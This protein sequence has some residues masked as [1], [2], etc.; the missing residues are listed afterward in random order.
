MEYAAGAVDLHC[1]LLPGIDDGAPDWETTLSMARV[2][3]ADGIRT[4]VATPHWPLD[5]ETSG[6]LV[7]ELAA[8][9]QARLRAEEVPL[10]VLPGHEL[11]I[12]WELEESLASGEALPLGDSR[13]VLLETP[14]FELPSYLRDLIFRLQGQSYRP[15]LAHP[16]RNPTVQKDPARLQPLVEAGCLLQ[17]NGGSLLGEFGSLP[18]RT[19]RALMRRG[20]VQIL[21]S[22]AHSDA[23]RPPR[24][25]RAA[26]AAARSVGHAA[27]QAMIGAAPFAVIQDNLPPALP[28]EPARPGLVER[29]LGRA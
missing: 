11:Q 5:G 16:E 2:A 9:A 21:A 23:D 26:R 8:E 7:R 20:W 3:A 29:L 25:A 4:I 18:R 17:V 27:A 22:D 24:L 10:R 12:V 14:Y 15:I 13:F 6:P 28:L 1:H 19:A